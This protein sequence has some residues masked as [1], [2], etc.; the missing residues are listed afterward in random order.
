MT[1]LNTD[2]CVLRGKKVYQIM[3]GHGLLQ[4]SFVRNWIFISW[5]PFVFI[6]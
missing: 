3:R 6:F 1:L 2:D 4:M 5:V